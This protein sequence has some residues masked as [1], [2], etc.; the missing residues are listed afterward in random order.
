MSQDDLQSAIFAP[1]I[2]P[3]EQ[4]LDDCLQFFKIQVKCIEIRETKKSILQFVDISKK[5]LYDE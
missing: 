5:V 1:K 4:S 3:D 2:G